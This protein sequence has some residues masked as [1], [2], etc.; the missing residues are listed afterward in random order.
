MGTRRMVRRG[1]K[2][3][4]YTRCYLANG[5]RDLFAGMIFAALGVGIVD[6]EGFCGEGFYHSTTQDSIS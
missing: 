5:I 6:A 1:G 3:G 4:S 2:D